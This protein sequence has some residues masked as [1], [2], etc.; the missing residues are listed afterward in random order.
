MLIPS[1]VFFILISII[2]FFR[3]DWFKFSSSLLKFSLCLSIFPSSVSTLIITAMTCLWG[4]LFIWV[5]L[6]FF[7]YFFFVLSFKKFS[8]PFLFCLTSSVSEFRWHIYLSQSW[9]YVLGWDHPCAVGLCPV[10]LE[11]QLDLKWVGAVFAR[12]VCWQLSPWSVMRLEVKGLEPLFPPSLHT[13]IV[14]SNLCLSGDQEGLEQ[15][16]GVD[17]GCTWKANQS[18]RMLSVCWLC[19]MTGSKQSKLCLHSLRVEFWFLI[20]VR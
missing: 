1:S 10:A 15:D 9:M 6:G 12:S 8:S 2:V 14:N 18:P 17:L 3:P 19:T 20:G 5:S 11:R 7:Q 16:R 13:P 4:E